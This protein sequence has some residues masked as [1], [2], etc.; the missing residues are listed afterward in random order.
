MIS[1]VSV[2]YTVSVT[3]H[4]T[5]D[6]PDA[7]Y[8]NIT[9]QRGEYERKLVWHVD[10]QV[11]PD[12]ARMMLLAEAIQHYSVDSTPSRLVSEAA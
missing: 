1:T 5:G 8:L 3:A 7:L 4:F 11:N 9:D 6:K 2:D 10:H 12:R